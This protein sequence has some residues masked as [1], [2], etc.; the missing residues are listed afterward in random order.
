MSRLKSLLFLILFILSA[1]SGVYAQNATDY[2]SLIRNWQVYHDRGEY[3]KAI[4]QA[5]L[6]YQ[7]GEN[8][9][10]QELMA[11]ALNWEG[12]SLFKQPK[13]QAANRKS[14]KKAF[15]KSLELI[16]AIDNKTLQ[17]DNFKRLREIA[18]QENDAQALAV[19]E[20]RINDIE[21]LTTIGESNRDLAGQV[22]LLDRE[23]RNLS[24]RVDVLSAA[25]MKAELM[26]AMQKN[27]LDSLEMA[28]MTDAFLLE[29]NELEL[30]E[31][32][33]QLEL[34]Q[35]QVALQSS[36][37]KFYVALA[38]AG[39]LM[40][41]VLIMLAG[42]LFLRFTE[43]KKYNAIL[44]AKNEALIAERERSEMLLLN[45]LPGMVA[46]ELKQKG[47]TQARRYDK[48]TV[49]FTDFKDFS[50]I[51][52]DMPPEQLVAELDYYFKAFDDIIGKYKIEKI[53]TIGDSYMCVGGLP[54]VEGSQPKDVIQAALEI[55]DLLGQFK[56]EREKRN[57]PYFEA[58]IGIHTGPLVAGVVGSRK[59]AYDIW[60]DTVNI[61]SRLETSG[62][63]WRVNVS[64]VTF[65]LVKDHF[66]F[67]DR[68]S[69]AIKNRGEMGMYYVK[70][71]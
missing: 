30:K 12:Q 63:A 1:Q 37:R 57:Q 24:Q 11:Q 55:Q 16:A 34:I 48:A 2:N 62:E 49:M 23:K 31:K 35:N 41:V 39:G 7:L 43:I 61:A 47:F 10:N 13:R 29:K 69:I 3:D 8:T 9:Q 26:L 50:A 52:R 18:R 60:G 27:Y 46:D 58:R 20:K 53:K 67:E 25:Q 54:D 68:G 19:Y 71:A 40:A 42:G 22:E 56:Q 5:R 33:I 36:Q 65:E 45:I 14:A 64:S 15:E 38:A 6:I 4:E 28:R 21:N 32:N 44:N 59:F 70:R 66:A 51:A 17:L